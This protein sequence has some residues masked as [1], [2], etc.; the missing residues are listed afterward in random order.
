METRVRPV[1]GWAW[2][3][4]KGGANSG[5][6]RWMKVVTAAPLAAWVVIF[7]GLPEIVQIPRSGNRFWFDLQELFDQNSRDWRVEY[8]NRQGGLTS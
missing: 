5:R 6:Q 8:S 1:S 3:P 4:E 2:R 7:F